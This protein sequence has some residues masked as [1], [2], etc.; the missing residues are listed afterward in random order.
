MWNGRTSISQWFKAMAGLTRKEDGPVSGIAS[1]QAQPGWETGRACWARQVGI[2]LCVFHFLKKKIPL[3]FLYT[4][5][6]IQ[7]PK[8]PQDGEKDMMTSV[9]DLWVPL[10]H[11]LSVV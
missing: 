3:R 4:L 8:Q 7:T 9:C 1:L 6:K 11:R 10:P 2:K 5:S